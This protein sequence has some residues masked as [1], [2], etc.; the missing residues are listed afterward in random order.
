MYFFEYKLQGTL[1]PHK[2]LNSNSTLLFIQLPG[3]R[4]LWMRESKQEDDPIK[5]TPLSDHR[6]DLFHG[7]G[8]NPLSPTAHKTKTD[9][10]ATM[11]LDPF[12]KN[13]QNHTYPYLSIT[14]AW[15]HHE[16]SK[17]QTCDTMLIDNKQQRTQQLIIAWAS[18]TMSISS[19]VLELPAKHTA[20]ECK[21]APTSEPGKAPRVA[22]PWVRQ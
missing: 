11:V 9:Q 21:S 18:L 20:M 16:V 3:Q 14:M 12:A 19:R 10:T 8:V 1:P 2:I 13:W 6:I 17:A 7:F 15:V 4:N 22:G 5:S